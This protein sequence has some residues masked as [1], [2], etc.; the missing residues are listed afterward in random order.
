MSESTLTHARVLELFRYDPE[1]GDLVRR[2]SI[3]GGGPAGSVAGSVGPRGYLEVG[4]DG[5]RHKVHRVV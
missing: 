4:I 2:L 5:G 3:Q 1:T